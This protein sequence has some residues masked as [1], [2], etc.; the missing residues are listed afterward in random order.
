[1]DTKTRVLFLCTGNSARSQMAEAFL[2]RLGGDR[3]EVFSA[4]LEPNGVHP[5]TLRV[6]AEKQIDISD[7]YSKSLSAYIGRVHFGYLITVCSRAEQS[8]PIFPG[9]G[10]R[11]HW[12]FDDPAVEHGDEA[13]RLARFRDVRDRI[14]AR[15]IEWLSA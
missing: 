1:M 12:P 15:I 14:E 8:C 4:G 11:L 9:M 6:M 5:L 3:Y 10:V 13:A 2:R 7:Q